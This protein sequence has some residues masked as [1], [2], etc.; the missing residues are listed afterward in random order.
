MEIDPSTNLVMRAM[1]QDLHLLPHKVQ[2]LQ[3][4]ADP[5]RAERDAVG[6]TNFV[7][8]SKTILISWI[9]FFSDEANFYFS[10]HV[11]KKYVLLDSA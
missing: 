2:I 10:G 5:N 8:E 6:Q 7:S 11:H 3:L 4:H 9:S 1:H